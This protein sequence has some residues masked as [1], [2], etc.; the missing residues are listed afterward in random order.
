M[1]EPRL[2]DREPFTVLGVKVRV[3]PMTADYRAIWGDLYGP[4]DDAVKPFSRDGCYYSVYFETEEEGK[5]DLVVGMA[6]E[7]VE[8]APE[9]LLLCQVPGGREAVFDCPVSAIGP[10]WHAIFEEW[11]PSSGYRHDCDSAGFECFPPGADRGEVPVTIHVP[12]RKR[13]GA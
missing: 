2:Q 5:D 12:V 4:H 6:V 1:T 8:S 9:G 3:N 13:N 10:T 11:M 7:G